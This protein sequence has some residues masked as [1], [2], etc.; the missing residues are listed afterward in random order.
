M[1]KVSDGATFTLL[2]EDKSPIKIRLHGIDAPEHYQP[3]SKVSRQF[4]N[5]M[6]YDKDVEVTK[7]DIDRYGR[8]IGMV[9]VDGMNVNE[10][11]LKSGLAWH[12]KQ[13]DKNPEW[14]KLE[15]EA[16]QNKRGLWADDTPM[17][18]WEWRRTTK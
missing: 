17:V 2:T 6:I 12:Y 4:I 5:D 1:I 14:A 16:R 15:N 9:F 7:M 8:T 13:Y 3:F 18:L 11:L 10:A